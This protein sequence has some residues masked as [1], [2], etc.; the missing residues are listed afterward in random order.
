M[1]ISIKNWIDLLESDVICICWNKII[2]IVS[3][4][5]K[6]NWEVLWLLPNVMPQMSINDF[7]CCMY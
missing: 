2:C 3:K 6:R 4:K 7:F 1:V 5:D